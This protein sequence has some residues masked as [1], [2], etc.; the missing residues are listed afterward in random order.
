MKYFFII[1][2]SFS[3]IA[4]VEK[5]VPGSPISASKMNKVLIQIEEQEVCYIEGA[6][7]AALVE[8][9]TPGVYLDRKFSKMYGD[10][11]FLSKGPV[12]SDRIYFRK[13]SFSEIILSKGEYLVEY[14]LTGSYFGRY[15]QGALFLNG[16]E[17]GLTTPS[18]SDSS[19]A[20]GDLMPLMKGVDLVSVEDET[21]VLSLKIKSSAGGTQSI[22]AV[23][24]KNSSYDAYSVISRLKITRR[25]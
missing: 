17:E 12:S 3:A 8:T 24:E 10:C 22:H 1:L 19:G 15:Q 25:Q 11:D 5:F 7:T 4:G 21:G 13:K 9:M 23:S 2:F 6:V 18:Y 16:V 20:W 14:S